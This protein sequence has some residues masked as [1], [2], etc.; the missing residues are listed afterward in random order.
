[1]LNIV[2]LREQVYQYLRQEMHTG[3]LLPG[4]TINLTEMSKHLGISKTPLRDA[5]IRLETEGF[6]TIL[7]RRG[8]KVNA[9]TLEDVKDSYDLIGALEGWVILRIFDDLDPYLISE[10]ERMNAEMVLAIYKDDFDAYYDLNLEFHDVYLALSDNVML[11]NFIT[12]VKQRLYDF[13][14]RSYIKEWELRNCDEHQLFI[15]EIKGG[16]R[17]RAVQVMRDVHWSYEV[18]AEFIKEFY[19]LVRNQIRA[20]RAFNQNP[21][22]ESSLKKETRMRPGE[23]ALS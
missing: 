4:S 14:R 23:L 1:M 18:Q 17:E 10:M 20:E 6:I 16:N 8:V 19:S 21:A 3:R 5:L 2:S 7:P 15:D 22:E 11:R 9:L 13:P 12:P